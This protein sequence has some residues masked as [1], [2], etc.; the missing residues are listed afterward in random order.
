[1]RTVGKTDS[2]GSDSSDQQ[3]T[4]NNQRG[5][6]GVPSI[7]NWNG[8]PWRTDLRH[9]GGGGSEPVTMQTTPQLSVETWGGGG[10][11]KGGVRARRGLGSP[12]GMEKRKG[13]I[14]PGGNQQ[15]LCF[16]TSAV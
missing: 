4:S 5:G 3:A 8:K 13:Y 14:N 1:M 15:W 6:T 2:L 11:A 7:P 10:A 9:R 16:F 12:A